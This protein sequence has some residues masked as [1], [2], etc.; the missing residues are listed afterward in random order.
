MN[1]VSSFVF[2][3]CIRSATNLLFVLGLYILN[4]EHMKKFP[5]V[6]PTKTT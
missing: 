6:G 3:I 4:Y 5:Q 2:T 1:I